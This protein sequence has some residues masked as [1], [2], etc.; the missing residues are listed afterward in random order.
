MN[1]A[2]SA[3]Y[4]LTIDR[5]TPTQRCA[6]RPAG[7]Q[8]WRSLLFM[9]WPVPIDTLRRLVPAKL[10]LDL[11]DGCAYVGLVPFAMRAI[12]PWWCPKALGFNFLETNVRT[13]VVHRGRP[14]VY[15][16]SLEASSRIA[17]NLARSIWALP[18]HYARMT[19]HHADAE[20]RYSSHRV[21]G[22]D[23]LSVRY[24]VG[25]SLPPS[26]LG[27][28]EFFFLERYLLFVERQGAIFSGQVFHS[29]YP[30]QT[31]FVDEVDDQLIA[32]A[33][34]QKVQG[35]PALTH[36]SAGVDVEVFP[37]QRISNAGE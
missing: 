28:L 37:L 5:I 24:R 14:G 4:D 29:P 27:S 33:G 22:G 30:V 9:H 20:M 6:G 10:E 34:L 31:A 16:F 25:S 3:P 23:S 1:A 19:M 11:Y 32:A 2:P 26:T 21:R 13:Y 7:Y 12:R 17:V 36:Y 35:L 18:Y 8:S 15:F